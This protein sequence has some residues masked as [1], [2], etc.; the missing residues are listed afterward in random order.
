MKPEKQFAATWF[1]NGKTILDAQAM[2][3]SLE[4]SS[5]G[6]SQSFET[7]HAEDHPLHTA[8]FEVRKEKKARNSRLLPV[9]GVN[10]TNRPIPE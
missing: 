10:N 5:A 8:D 9:Q 6:R 3:I 2:G 1:V 4:G 7:Y